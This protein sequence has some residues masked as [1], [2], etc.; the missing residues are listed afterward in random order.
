M[1]YINIYFNTIT[2]FFNTIL[3]KSKRIFRSTKKKQ[4]D[5]INTTKNAIFAR[6]KTKILANNRT[7]YNII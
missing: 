3:N 7:V 4:I 1:T 6:L 2:N 5:S